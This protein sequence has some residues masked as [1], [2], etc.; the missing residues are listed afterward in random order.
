L[1]YGN[2]GPIRPN[3]SI[4]WVGQDGPDWTQYV[5]GINGKH[6][7]GNG[8]GTIDDIDPQALLDNFGKRH[9]FI[10][11]LHTTSEIYYHLKKY[12]PVA[13][14]FRYKLYVRDK[15]GVPVVAHG[16]AFTFKTSNIGITNVTMSTTNSSLEP[17]DELT[18]YDQNQNKLHI[19]LT[20]NDQTDRTLSDAIAEFIIVT[21]NLPNNE[22]F[23]LNISSGTQMQADGTFNRI[24][25]T[26]ANGIYTGTAPN[27][28]NMMVTTI[29]THAECNTTG[30]VEVQIIGGTEPYTYQWN[31]GENIVSTSSTTSITDLTPGIYEV[32]VTDVNG[33]TEIRNAEVYGQYIPIFDADGNQIP[34]NPN[35]CPTLLTLDGNVP[36]GTYQ[37]NIA[38]NSDGTILNNDNVQYKA[39]DI[40][41]LN[42]DFEVKPGASFEAIIEDCDGN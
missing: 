8:D 29:V 37:A 5:Q 30:Q 26:T 2:S 20:R 3:A 6:Q 10:P 33:V 35:L 13:G 18:V 21:N 38:V 32:T 17:Y 7:D 1:A 16:L 11:V 4:E 23:D 41:I 27:N 14:N 42:G 24:A 36:S 34:C 31:T 40:I 28:G 22:E 12:P 25:G 15:S 9:S 19:A 39:G